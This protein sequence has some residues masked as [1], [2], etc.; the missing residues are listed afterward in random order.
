MIF[1][2][3]KTIILLLLAAV[4]VAED[5]AHAEKA[6]KAAVKGA[7]K[8]SPKAAVTKKVE[9]TQKANNVRD[10]DT[11][12][13]ADALQAKDHKKAAE[14]KRVAS[15][16]SKE[17][18]TAKKAADVKKPAETKK[19]DKSKRPDEAKKPAEPKLA[20]KAAVES[21][22]AD[23]A[24]KTAETKKSDKSK[25]LA[26]TKKVDESKTTD[27]TKKPAESKEADKLNKPDEAKKPA[28]SKKT[29]KLNKVDE[30]KKPAESK[31]ADKMS[32]PDE[33]KK[34]AET[35]KADKT[36][37]PDE[38]KK[39]AETKKADKLNKPDEAK[40]PAETKKTDKLNKPDEATKPPGAKEVGKTKEL[41]DPKKPT[42]T[43]KPEK[44]HELSNTAS[45]ASDTAVVAEA[46]DAG[47]HTQLQQ[48]I[49]RHKDEIAQL[50]AMLQKKDAEIAAVS[51]KSGADKARESD[52]VRTH[53]ERAKKS[54]DEASKARK[55]A[56]EKSDLVKR[57]SAQLAEASANITHL[58]TEKALLHNKFNAD[59]IA[60]QQHAA[61][62]EKHALEQRVKHLSKRL[63]DP[64]LY[65]AVVRK[66]HSEGA[67]LLEKT[68]NK[69]AHHY[70]HAI[71]MMGHVV[72]SGASVVAAGH[73]I[74]H[75]RIK[76]IAGEHAPWIAVIFIMAVLTV[77]CVLLRALLSKVVGG[78][79][80]YHVLLVLNLYGLLVTLG[81]FI[82]SK[83]ARS[84]DAL[85][86][87]KEYD[88]P[89]QLGQGFFL[90]IYIFSIGVFT[91]SFQVK[92]KLAKHQGPIR[93]LAITHL[94]FAMGS[95]WHYYVTAIH[96]VLMDLK[97]SPVS[98]MC[99]IAHVTMFV[100]GLVIA[101]LFEKRRVQDGTLL[102]TSYKES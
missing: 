50:K 98:T 82:G 25:K 102:P 94:V 37:K 83:L 76:P 32:K 33:A 40:K 79:G 14:S 100:V 16:E 45:K 13:K 48:Q 4:V 85:L 9:H 21:K 27:E 38:A 59:K 57:L 22:T 87:A 19:A 62:V 61:E 92:R 97:R 58:S 89:V 41:D 36:S 7:Q 93:M 5:G 54:A 55:E 88:E 49:A 63:E 70:G 74:I 17:D 44:R 20:V 1:L 69:T 86:A 43:K 2:S 71:G 101:P 10:A 56:I 68:L 26:E 15:T 77:P 30:A 72:K 99:Y 91:T 24:K 46:V 51:V 23:E 39:P 80:L 47:A 3:R 60:A 42:D 78:L 67:L 96:P 90:C 8:E 6:A 64:D 31:K 18:K 52:E 53:R 29:N 95:G 28:E 75:D 35:K 66:S 73:G 84:H 65:E 12:K 11:P 81:L 34:P